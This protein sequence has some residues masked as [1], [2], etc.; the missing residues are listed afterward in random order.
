MAEDQLFAYA[1]RGFCYV[2]VVYLLWRDREVI[3]AFRAELG[4]VKEKLVR[5]LERITPG[6]S[7]TQKE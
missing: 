1:D 2:L 4:D 6:S 5:L 3:T 7:V